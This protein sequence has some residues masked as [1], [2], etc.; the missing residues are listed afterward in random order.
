VNGCVVR[1]VMCTDPIPGQLAAYRRLWQLLLA[2]APK[3]TNA[4]EP[5]SPEASMTDAVDQTAPNGG[6]LHDTTPSA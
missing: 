6:M 5:G 3:H 2:D 4:P 1:I